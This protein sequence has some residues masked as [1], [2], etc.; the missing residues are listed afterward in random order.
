MEYH[1]WDSI[2]MINVNK[3]FY[4]FQN[5]QGGGYRIMKHTVFQI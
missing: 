1:G 4:D 3:T 2:F 5:N